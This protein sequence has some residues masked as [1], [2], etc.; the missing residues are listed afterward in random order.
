MVN[1]EEPFLYKSTCLI[2]TNTAAKQRSCYHDYSNNPIHAQSHS[3]LQLL[4]AAVITDPVTPDEQSVNRVSQS[5][6]R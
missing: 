5:V 4:S 6:N 3:H 1:S 2:Q